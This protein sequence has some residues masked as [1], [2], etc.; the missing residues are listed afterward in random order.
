MPDAI[1]AGPSEGHRHFAFSSSRP[2]VSLRSRSEYS[3]AAVAAGGERGHRA[4]LGRGQVCLLRTRGNVGRHPI[5]ETSNL[6]RIQ[7]LTLH[8][9]LRLRKPQELDGDGVEFGDGADSVLDVDVREVFVRE[10]I[11]RTESRDLSGPV[12]L[13]TLPP[14]GILLLGCG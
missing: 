1:N 3:N 4:L 9:F 14:L 5:A 10:G 2:C 12:R 6:H 8:L 13:S 7:L 11:R